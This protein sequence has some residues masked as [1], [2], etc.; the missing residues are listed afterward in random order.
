M[1]KIAVLTDFDGTIA[2]INVMDS[3][4]EKFGGPSHRVYMERWQR[5]E[6]STMEEIQGV[7]NTVTADR[8]EMESF[9]RTVELDPGFI[10][11]LDFCL[12]HDLAFA[13]V[14][15][16]FRWYID[17]IL[18]G[19]G[20]QEVSI[21]AGD[22]RFLDNGFEF[23]FPWYDPAYPLRSTAKPQIVRDYQRRGF[24]VFF[25]GDGFSDLEVIGVADLIYAK[26]VLLAAAHDQGLD[27]RAFNTLRDV[28]EDLSQRVISG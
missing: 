22:I 7:F 17:Y 10:G 1:S 15:D 9:L 19:H 20:L 26:D 3:L 8:E 28:T 11:L 24:K 13:I 21:Y 5:G 18:E 16:G 14:S 27:V 25:V 4:Y 2:A 6:I 23:D 12:Q